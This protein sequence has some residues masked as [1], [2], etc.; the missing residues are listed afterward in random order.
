MVRVRVKV[1][2]TPL[3]QSSEMTVTEKAHAVYESSE[4]FSV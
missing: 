3:S 2:V 1:R 4:F